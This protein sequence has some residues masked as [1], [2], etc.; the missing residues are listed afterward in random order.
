MGKIVH[1]SKWRLS[2]WKVAIDKSIPPLP[3]VSTKRNRH[4]K[5]RHHVYYYRDML[6][7]KIGLWWARPQVLGWLLKN[8]QPRLDMRK[9]R[10][11]T[12]SFYFDI[13]MPIWVSKTRGTDH[14]QRIYYVH[15]PSRE[16]RRRCLLRE[17]WNRTLL[18]RWWTHACPPDDENRTCLSILFDMPILK[19][20]QCCLGNRHVYFMIL[21]D[22]RLNGIEIYWMK[23]TWRTR[24]PERKYWS[25]LS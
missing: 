2:V 19:N 10:M 9:D 16:G 13:D 1:L 14:D 6:I 15:R 5:L 20:K 17:K 11:K 4:E 24:V 21:V 22:T 8:K 23:I 12:F 25:S 18:I 3:L 7:L